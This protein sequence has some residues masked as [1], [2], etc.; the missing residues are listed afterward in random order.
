MIDKIP[1]YEISF[2]LSL[3]LQDNYLTHFFDEPLM[4]HASKHVMS[5]KTFYCKEHKNMN[6][7]H[8]ELL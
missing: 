8:L 4:Q 7:Y 6:Y 5:K 2:Q 3:F 1:F